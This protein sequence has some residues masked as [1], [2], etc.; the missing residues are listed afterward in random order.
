MRTHPRNCETAKLHDCNCGACG[1]SQHGARWVRLPHA[2]SEDRSSRRSEYEKAL[3]YDSRSQLRDNQDNREAV[4]DI[5]RLDVADWLADPLGAAM[6]VAEAAPDRGRHKAI[7]PSGVDAA[8][9]ITAMA[10]TMADAWKEFAEELAD[11]PAAPDIRRSFA[12]HGW[13]DLLVG[14]V[15][16]IEAFDGPVASIPDTAKAAVTRYILNSTMQPRRAHITALVAEVIVD[17]A[18]LAFKTALV[19]QIPLIGTSREQAILI[20][21]VLAVFVCPAPERHAE[22]QRFALKPIGDD[23]RTILLPTTKDRLA[24]LFA[25]WRNGSVE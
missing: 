2:S 3:R 1:G 4:T 10:A 20:L 8:E 11:T 21:R 12:R 9:Q 18:W 24:E 23:V 19:S 13:C 5:A 7:E 25:E 15:Q 22:V 17:K 14:I 6:A 16:A